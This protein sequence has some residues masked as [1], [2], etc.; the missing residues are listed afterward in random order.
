M[1]T[2]FF[3]R[4]C[5]FTVQLGDPLPI[6]VPLMPSVAAATF[7]GLHIKFKAEKD[8]LGHPNTL[9]LEVFNL[10]QATRKKL[11]AGNG[12]V[13]LLAGYV[14]DL[15]NLPVVFQGNARTIDHLRIGPDWVTK[16][17]C[18]DGET[19]YRFGQASQS[20]PAGTTGPVIAQYLAQQIKA[21]DPQHIDI[22]G[23]VAKAPSLSYPLFAFVWGYVTTGN[24][25]EELQRLLGGQYELSLQNGELR[26]LLPKEAQ[27]GIE[28]PKIAPGYGMIGSPE[29]GTPNLNGLP[30][31]LKVKSLLIPRVHPG[32]L[33]SIQARD[34]TGTFRVQKII[35][36][37]DIA[38]NDW[39][40]EL[41]CMPLQS[42]A[43]AAP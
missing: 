8:N 33:V 30:S 28:V 43:T 38:G 17:Q 5:Q 36:T 25:F 42:A 4:A 35:H 13:Q 14:G 22:T 7:T 1:S 19:A 12:Y 39:Q 32:D 34:I 24:A 20:F 26:A 29:H 41:E 37:G 10:S 23:F 15:P 9:D 27:A 18:G 6:V 3:G 40:S 2:P 11:Q 16:I 31:I 21:A